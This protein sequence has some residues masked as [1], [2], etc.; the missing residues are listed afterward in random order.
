MIA[1]FLTYVDDIP[2]YK[3]K[4]Y[5]YMYIYVSIYMFPIAGLLEESRGGGKKKRMMLNNIKI[6]C[7]YVGIR[8]NEMP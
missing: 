2:K 3:Y 7:K 4:N 1:C 8:H 5:I 6:H